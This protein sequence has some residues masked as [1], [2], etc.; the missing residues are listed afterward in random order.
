MS[1]F[2]AADLQPGDH[3]LRVQMP[4]KDHVDASPWRMKTAHQVLGGRLPRRMNARRLD[5]HEVSPRPSCMLKSLVQLVNR[6]AR[7]L[8]HDV[9]TQGLKRNARRLDRSLQTAGQLA[10]VRDFK[11]HVRA[12][13]NQSTVVVSSRIYM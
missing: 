2:F 1:P 4:A 7:G 10:G 6:K 3:V 13:A 11:E 8:V 9:D 12:I 5:E